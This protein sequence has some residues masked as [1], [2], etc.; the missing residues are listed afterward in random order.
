MKMAS[1]TK[2]KENQDLLKIIQA[3]HHDPFAVLGWFKQE[4]QWGYRLFRPDAE[5]VFIQFGNEWVSVPRV[6]GSD[7]FEVNQLDDIREQHPTIRL[8]L[9]SNNETSFVDPY[10]FFPCLS[11]GEL[12]RFN[13]ADFHQ[14]YEFMG[15]LITEVDGIEGVRFTLWAPNAERVSVI[16]DFNGWDG[17]IT[18]MRNR[19]RSGIWELFIPG[20]STGTLYKFEIRNRNSGSVFTKSDPFAHYC[21]LPPKTASIVSKKSE[22]HWHD[23]LWLKRRERWDWLHQPMSIYEVHL[24]S[25]RKHDEQ[26]PRYREIAEELA[27]YVKQQGFTHVQL[28]PITE[29]PF[30][31]SWGYQVTGYYAPTCRYGTEDDFRYFIDYLHKQDIG[32]LLDWVPGH[33]PKDEHGLARFDGT[34]LFEYGDPNKGE[35]LD[36]GT[37]IF[38][39]SRQEVRNFLLSSAYYWVKEYHID[40]LRVDAVAS[41]LY[42]DYSRDEWTPNE[43]GGNENLEAISF[44]RA[45]NEQLHADF[46]GVLVIA[47][48]STAWP[49][50]SRPVYL[51]GLGF[52][53][54][55]NMGWMNDTLSYIQKAPIHRKYHHDKLTFSLLYAFS[56]N[57]ILPFSHDEVVHG[58]GSILNKMPGD[59][60]QKFANVRLLYTYQMT[61]PGKKLL[62]MGCEF[63]QGDEWNHSKGLDWHLLEYDYQKGVQL[64]IADLNRIYKE[65]QALHRYDFDQKGFEWIDCND[66]D[67]SILSYL[68]KADD[69]FV[70]V[71]LNFTPEVR[72]D[73]RIGVPQPGRYREIFNSD[74]IY[75]RGSNISN[76]TEIH[77]E[78]QE[79]MGRPY[80]LSLTLPPLSGVILKLGDS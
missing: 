68:R 41:M 59:D 38:N 40:G 76:G 60:W 62:F 18:P 15:A 37:L 63:A 43:F 58:K 30:D 46:P 7:F 20:L 35:H 61:H 8:Q 53:M 55:W 33:F 23:D 72:A 29:H 71:I 50:V 14:A 80:S 36:W 31:G 21:E 52:S 12:T 17:R 75:Y 56:E 42:L 6:K 69:E 2:T 44:I 28:M 32:V 74:S 47:E 9:K 78:Q 26:F 79:W 51:G 5:A 45:L 25:W 39:Y 4:K 77:S 1:S 65:E 64:S 67:Q 27:A 24:G 48:E 3:R 49:Q 34:P 19:G 22:F 11:E 54:K 66:S 57:F 16:G 73:Y 13:D 10:S 70:L